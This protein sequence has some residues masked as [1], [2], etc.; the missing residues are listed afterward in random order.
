MKRLLILVFAL[1]LLGAACGS[2][3]SS[4]SVDVGAGS[5]DGDST[6]QPDDAD[7]GETDETE[8]EPPLGAPLGGGP[9]P[10]GTLQ[11]VVT[12][13]NGIDLA[14]TISCLG[15]TATLTGDWSPNEEDTIANIAAD[16]M[17]LRLA[18]DAVQ[19]RLINGVPGNQIC[20]E[21]YGGPDVATVSGE[22]DGNP[23]DAEF[24]RSNGCGID[25]W[26]NVM[27]GLLPPSQGIE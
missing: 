20:T 16:T 5:G 4:D 18:E 11:F 26:D 6:S 2:S 21:I 14:Y 12:H 19:Q 8:D 3:D 24:N 23:I 15:D 9:Y 17:C 10:V 7:L 1:G 27:T 22:L 13:P 25:D